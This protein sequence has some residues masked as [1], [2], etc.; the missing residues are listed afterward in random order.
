MSE[1]EQRTCEHCGSTYHGRQIVR[2]PKAEFERWNEFEKQIV[3]AARNVQEERSRFALVVVLVSFSSVLIVPWTWS[4]F[5]VSDS[6]EM[7]LLM[8]LLHSI[9][10]WVMLYVNWWV[11]HPRIDRRHDTTA[12]K[13]EQGSILDRASGYDP[14]QFKHGE[15]VVMERVE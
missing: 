11:I 3:L 6:F 2:L 1:Y 15:Y 10:G 9:P 4:F 5:N 12:S 14:E 8:T 13:Q 7:V